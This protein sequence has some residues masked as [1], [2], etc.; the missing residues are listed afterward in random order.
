MNP[1]H[2]NH[3]HLACVQDGT[4]KPFNPG[5]FGAQSPEESSETG[6]LGV[7]QTRACANLLFTSAGVSCVLV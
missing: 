4:D 7:F 1:V 3:V 2:H 5:R 6:M